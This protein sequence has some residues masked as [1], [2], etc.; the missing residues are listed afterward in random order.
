MKIYKKV[1]SVFIAFTL[2][3]ISF[4][5]SNITNV[6]AA[7][8]NIIHIFGTDVNVREGKSTSAKS[9][10]KINHDVA[11]LLSDEGEWLK[12]KYNDI[13]GY[14]KYNSGWIRK[15]SYNPNNRDEAFEGQISAFPDSY[16]DSLRLLHALYPDWKFTPFNVNLTLAEAVAMETTCTNHGYGTDNHKYLYY[17]Y[18]DSWRSMDF[19]CYDWSTNTFVEKESGGWT[20]ASREIVAFYMEPRNFLNPYEIYM[21][22]EQKYDPSKQNA[23]G[24][25]NIVKGTFLERPYTDIEHPNNDGSYINAIMNA[26]AQSNVSPYIIASKIIQEQGVEGTSS[27]ISGTYPGYVGYYNYFNIKAYGD[28]IVGNGLAYATLQKDPTWNTRQGAIIGGAKF[29]GNNY[30]SAGQSTYYFQDY[31]MVD[32]NIHHQYATAVHDARSKGVNVASGYADKFNYPLEFTIP[33][34]KNTT[35]TP[36]QKP[37]NSNEKNN[38][39]I[40]SISGLTPTFNMYKFTDYSLSLETDGAID[41]VLPSGATL[42]TNDEFRL[43]AGINNV[44]LTVKSETGFTNS[45]HISVNAANNCTLYINKNGSSSNSGNML[46]DVNGDGKITIGDGGRIV[47][48][49]SEK[50]ILS[51][52][53]FNAADI[54][55]DGAITIGDG[56]KIVLHLLGRLNIE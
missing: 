49:L 51:G 35:A 22:L 17:T 21:F 7:E 37:A 53:A 31:N 26:A 20:G 55:K 13:V 34:F 5:N 11:E 27:L 19:G 12:I 46:G 25:S 40:S 32:L 50:N 41:V 33:V 10:C 24:L 3:F 38:Y 16:K 56:G 29:L 15:L 8:N 2:L 54:N 47:L 14:I 45:Y 23:E 43:S 30:I 18:G 28:D 44:V 6:S 48:H 9:L 4:F 39:Y 42:T 1:L 52:A 36:A